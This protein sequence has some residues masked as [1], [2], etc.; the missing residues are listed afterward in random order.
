MS[1][2]PASTAALLAPIAAPKTSASGSRVLLNVSAFFNARPPLTTRAAD[3]NSGRSDLVNVVLICVVGEFSASMGSKAL[4]S[5]SDVESASALEKAVVR[6]VKIVV[7]RSPGVFTVAIAFPAY[8]GRV[9]VV[10]LSDAEWDTDVMS[11]MAG[12]SRTP[13][14]RGKRFFAAEVWAE[15]KWLYSELDNTLLS[16]GVRFSARLFEYDSDVEWRMEV[17]PFSLYNT[18]LQRGNHSKGPRQTY[19]LTFSTMEST[20]PG[21]PTTSAVTL[22]LNSEAAV[23]AERHPDSTSPDRC[24]M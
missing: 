5:T 17:I 9:N 7:L 22:P 13:D 3:P 8:I 16:N 19:F 12:T 18:G 15:M 11:D 4:T 20:S 24:S 6:T 23:S 21:P 2:Y 14:N 1:A 10:E